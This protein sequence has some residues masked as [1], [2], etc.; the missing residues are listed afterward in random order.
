VA[1]VVGAASGAEGVAAGGEFA[2]EAGQVAVVPMAG[3]GQGIGVRGS[4]TV[5]SAA[6]SALTDGIGADTVEC[7]ATAESFSLAPADQCPERSAQAADGGGVGSVQVRGRPWVSRVGM[8]RSRS[9]VSTVV[10][11]TP[12]CSPTR[13]RDQPRL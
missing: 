11:L 3:I 5:V 10:W 1:Q 12:R 13:A 9:V 8:P 6:A 4:A 7:V 2:D